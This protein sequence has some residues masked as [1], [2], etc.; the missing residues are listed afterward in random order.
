M[1]P[2]T[3]YRFGTARHDIR[4][5]K[6]PPA[7]S[8]APK[9]KG[10][11]M[12]V[13]T[14]LLGYAGLIAIG[15]TVAICHRS[16]IPAWVVCTVAAAVSLPTLLPLL[17]RWQKMRGLSHRFVAAAMHFLIVGSLAA[18]L[19]TCA[20]FFITTST[21]EVEVT[22]T[23]KYTEWHT[24]YRRLT[25]GRMVPDGKYKTY[26]AELELPD[27]RTTSTDISFT[28]YRNLRPGAKRHITLERG[29]FGFSVIKNINM[30]PAPGERNESGTRTKSVSR[31]NPSRYKKQTL[32]N[33]TDNEQNR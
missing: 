22:V 5:R 15:F 20:N 32:N 2:T 23:R 9:D 4:N 27:G 11:W 33:N 17:P 28:R 1:N 12:I 26:H 24:H 7:S 3:D 18:L 30:S 10:A 8:P 19:F 31:S 16:F 6:T 25:R 13:L 29:V 14:V 21:N